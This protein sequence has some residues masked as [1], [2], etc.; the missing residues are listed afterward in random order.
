MDR[1]SLAILAVVFCVAGH[2]PGQEPPRK[3]VLVIGI[4]GCRTD[5][6]LAAK[7]PHLRALIEQGAFAD[8]TQILGPRETGSDTVS[9]PGWSSILTG[10]WADKHGA[11]D[12]QF[13]GTDYG[14]YPHF[15]R[16]LKDARPAA[17]TASLVTWEPIHD[18]IVSAAD[19]NLLF[20][21]KDKNYRDAD[22]A[23]AKKA[24]ELLA[25]KDPDAVFVYFGNVDETGHEKGFHPTIAEYMRAIE[26]VDAHIGAIRNA[27]ERRPAFAREDWLILVSTDHGGRGTEHGGGHAVPEIRNIFLIVSGPSARRGKITEPTFLVDI[28]ATALVHLGVPIDPK[29]NWDGRAVGLKNMP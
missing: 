24:A 9:G 18:L 25:T 15:F 6:L 27:I 29:W 8:D 7:A 19:E 16:K 10:V 20:R 13:K 22:A 4:D 14:Q 3:K 2:A 5:A 12:N 11:R 17:F 23:M 21:A 26:E 1:R 28:P